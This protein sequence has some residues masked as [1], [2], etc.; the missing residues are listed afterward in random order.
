MIHAGTARAWACFS[1]NG[2]YSNFPGLIQVLKVQMYFVKF[3]NG[4]PVNKQIPPNCRIP[5]VIGSVM[6]IRIGRRPWE[7]T[8]L[9]RLTKSLSFIG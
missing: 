4:P 6:V 3:V 2:G 1:G 8:E 7:K 5:K 9:L